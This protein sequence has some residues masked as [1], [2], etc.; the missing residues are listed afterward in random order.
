MHKS[1]Y[2]LACFKNVFLVARD[3]ELVVAHCDPDVKLPLNQ[4]YIFVV[5]AEKRYGVFCSPYTEKF[6]RKQ[7]P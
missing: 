1:L 5:A 7:S 4:F 6:I 2:D 3:F